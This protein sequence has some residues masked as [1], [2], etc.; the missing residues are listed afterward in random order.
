MIKAQAQEQIQ[1][2][3]IEFEVEFKETQIKMAEAVQAGEM[4]EDRM[5]LELGKLQEQMQ[6]QLQSAEIELTHRLTEEQSRVENK[7]ISEKEWKIFQKD[8]LFMENVVDFVKFYENRIKLCCVAGDKMLYE[9]YL[10]IQDYPIIPFHYKWTGTPFPMSA[11]SPLI[12]KQRELNKAHQLMVHNA[13]LGSSLRWMYEEGSIDTDYWEK[14]S[15]APGALLPKRAGFEA[16]TPVM[17]FQLNNA[18][19]GLVQN[20]KQDMEY[21]AGIYSSMQVFRVQ[22]ICLEV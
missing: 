11:V 7:I 14:Y 19:F 9:K 4:L 17:P 16:P 18:F 8:S 5:K 10:P 21:L 1:K 20:G 12:G 22:R 13:S 2:M 15:S 3:S 6:Q